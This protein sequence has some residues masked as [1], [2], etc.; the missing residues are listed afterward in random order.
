MQDGGMQQDWRPLRALTIA[1]GFASCAVFIVV[2]VLTRLEMFGDGSIFSYAV[3]AQDAWALHWH[4]ISGR[5]FTYVYAYVVPQQIV[6]FTGSARAGIAAYG[7]LFFSAPLFGLLMTVATD[8]S[9]T[10]AL[11]TY[12]CFSTAALCPFVYGA[13]TEMWMAQALFWPALALCIF[14]PLNARGAAAVFIALLALVFTHEGAV[15]LALAILAALLLRGWRYLRF[16]RALIAFGAAMVIWAT[17]KLTIE[18]DAYIAGVIHDAAFKFI[19]VRN[20]AQPAFFTIVAALTGYALLVAAFDVLGIG[21]FRLLAL[22]ICIAGLAMFWLSFDRWMLSEARYDV[23]TVLL[24]GVPILGVLAAIQS[25]TAE[26]WDGSP[27]GFLVGWSK[28][29]SGLANPTTLAGGLA[30]V[31]L[32]QAVETV[33]FVY[34]WTQY[35]AAVRALAI[36][37]I[38][39]PQLGSPL[40]VSSQRIAPDLN[41]LGWNST[42]PFLSVLVVPDLTPS[43][44]VVDPSAGYFWLSCSTAKESERTSTAIPE[45]ARG[46]ILLHACLH[47]P[48]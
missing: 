10:R 32:V 27:L 26:E 7:A 21:R 45:Q 11:F 24:I 3:A 18:P 2:G 1:G 12:A 9:P 41:R 25:M 43:R 33:K 42:T 35:K 30:L 31:L 5:L 28:T 38:S 23:R 39:D 19:D 15:V 17:V 20:L 48:D 47:R 44:L 29:I 8:R 37:T 13:P 22:T 46:L 16:V 14:A 40:F 6:A 36:G 4:N 34:D